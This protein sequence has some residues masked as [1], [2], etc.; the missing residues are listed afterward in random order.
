MFWCPTLWNTM[1]E[2]TY[3]SHVYVVEMTPIF[4]V[5]YKH[6]PQH[7]TLISTAAMLYNAFL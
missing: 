3:L 1:I 5:G 7:M 4:L 2:S 6:M